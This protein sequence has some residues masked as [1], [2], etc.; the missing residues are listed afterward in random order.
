MSAGSY[1]YIVQVTRQLSIDIINDFVKRGANIQLI[2]GAVESSYQPLDPSVKVTTFLKYRNSSNTGRIVTG[3]LFT[4]YTFFFL[5]FTSRKKELILI[6]TPPFILYLGTFFKKIRNQKYHLIIWD[7]YPDILVNFGVIKENSFV[8]RIW[9]RRNEVCF[10]NASTLFTLGEHLSGAIR[11]YTT[12]TPVII[13]NWA[14]TDFV[15]PV[16][17]ADNRFARQHGLTDKFVVMYSGN[18][19]LTH[20]LETLVHTAKALKHNPAIQFVIIGDGAKRPVIEQ[21]VKEKDPG[22]VLLLPYQDRAMLPYSLAC[23]DVGVITLSEGAEDIS[24]PSKTYST[25]AA[26]AAI[27]ALASERSELGLLIKK[28]RCGTIVKGGNIQEAASFIDLLAKN[29]ETAEEYKKNA[30]QASRDFTPENAKR[31]YEE[32]HND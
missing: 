5:L 29:K 30:R 32:I 1:I 23:A 10:N 22:N 26:G 14:N 6:T 13:P 2:T 16:N 19:G 7:L 12:R 3:L 9:K 27:L 4:L 20:D 31:Y 24:V 25:L 17:R 8:H 28:Y 11:K 15:K 21:L 18:W